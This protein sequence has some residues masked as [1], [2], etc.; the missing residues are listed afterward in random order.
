MRI[1]ITEKALQPG[2]GHW[3]SYIGGIY[4]GD[5]DYRS[6]VRL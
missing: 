2:V 4:T 5:I 1:L 6:V 3:P